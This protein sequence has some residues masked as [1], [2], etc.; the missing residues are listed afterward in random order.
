M[1]I[2]TVDI[3]TL[4]LD[5]GNVRRHSERNLGAILTSMK[6]FGQQKPIVIGPGD[7]VVAGNGTLEAA[8]SLGWEKIQI[9]RTKLTGAEA[10]A[11]A[12]AD[13][14]T[15]DLADWWEE[16][17]VEALAAL[18]DEEGFDIEVTGY[19]EAEI[20]ELALSIMPGNPAESDDPFA[21]FEE[22]GKFLDDTTVR[23][24][25]GDYSALVGTAVY[26]SFVLAFR[27]RQAE[28]AEPMIDDVLRHWLGLA[29]HGGPDAQDENPENGTD[30]GETADS[31]SEA[32]VTL[33]DEG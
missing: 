28:E 4:K 29:A 5:E 30:D 2:E 9:V 21:R 8:R 22:G 10:K 12:I 26:N 16:G 32:Q 1:K 31:E 15:A 7:V 19:T 18:S 27:E 33:V 3:A 24:Q 17:L 14:R 6:Q 11:Y 20:E 13:N 25:F 23:F